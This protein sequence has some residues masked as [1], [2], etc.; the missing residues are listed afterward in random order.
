MSG[1]RRHAQHAGGRPLDGR[2]RAHSRA[3]A[4][5]FAG[6][7]RRTRGRDRYGC[8]ERR[9]TD[10]RTVQKLLAHSDASTTMIYTRVLE[11]AGGGVRNSLDDLVCP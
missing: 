4:A 9:G 7:Y 6:E 5:R 10:I 8:C 11:L 1:D 3:E 2:A